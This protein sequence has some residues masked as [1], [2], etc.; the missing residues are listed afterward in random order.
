[1]RLRTKI[2][3]AIV[4]ALLLVPSAAVY[5]VATTESGLRFLMKRLAK[6]GPITLTVTDI[7]GTLTE[8]IRFKS[9]RVQHRLADTTIEDGEGRAKLLPL[10]LR[11]QIDVPSF[12]ARHVT[13]VQLIDPVQRPKR[14]PRFL[15]AML[16]VDAES[17]R[18]GSV[19]LT[20]KNGR[21][22]AFSQISGGATVLPQQIRVRNASA[23]W[24][25][26]TLT[27]NGRVHAARPY[28]LDGQMV[29]VWQPEGQPTWQAAATFDGDLDDLPFNAAVSKPFN[30]TLK[31]NA[32]LR[33][34]WNIAG[35]AVVQD[36][37]LATFGGGNALGLI[38]GRL[39]VDVDRD[40]ITARGELTP[41]GLNA[42]AFGVD[43]RGAYLEKRLTIRE[44]RLVHAPSGARATVRGTAD[45]QP[46]G[47]LLALAGEWSQF[48]WP[49]IGAETAFTSPKGT[50]T[51][52]GSKPWQVRAD[53]D[54]LTPLLPDA[55]A[56]PVQARGQ[57]DGEMFRIDE[58]SAQLL[59]GSASFTG[60][61]RWKPAEGWQVQ[62]HATGLDTSQL[63][64][65]MPGKVSF[66]FRAGGAPFGDAGSIDLAI[67]SLSGTLRGQKAS[68]AGNFARAGGSTDW[69]FRDVDF[70]L[71]SAR[72]RLDGQLGE[73]P[74]LTFAL[75][76]A[77]LSL[78]D[79]DARGQ[80][81]ASGR[82]A[83]TLARPLLKLEARGSGFEWRGYAVAKL[84]A[85]LDIDLTSEPGRTQ[86]SLA[87]VDLGL[88]AR[89]I[90]SASLA[91]T[92]SGTR[93]Q[94][95]LI[96]D[97]APLRAQL[98]AEGGL[99]EGMWRGELTTLTLA[100]EGRDLLR[101]ETVAPIAFNFAQQELGQICLKG[102][103]ERL[104]ASGKHV[105]KGAWSAAFSANAL[106]LATF[107]AG[108][109]QE[110]DYDG[111][112]DL[113]GELSGAPGELPIG[114]VEG[115]LM[116]ARLRHRLGSGRE[117]VMSLGTGTVKANATASNFFFDV[118]MDA[119][120]AGRIRG[121][122][123][124]ERLRADWRDYPITG[125]LDA[126]TDALSLLDIYIGEI[127]KASGRM[128]TKVSIGGTLGTPTVQ[129]TLQLRDA[130]IDIYQINLALRELSLDASFDANAL[131]LS[132]KS[133]VGG[134]TANFNGRLAWR[135][136]QP[137]GQLHVDGDNLQVLNVPEARVRAS[138]DLD[139]K[140]EGRSIDATGT[141]TV[142]YA[143][144]EPLDLTTAVLRSS[145]EQFV[146]APAV[147]PSQ[148][149]TVLSDIRLEMG[150]DVRV[151]ALGL[152]ARLAGGLRLR[153]DAVQNTRAQGELT[154]AE[155]EFEAYGR[156]LEI[157]S[158]GL[159]YTNTPIND[160]GIELR[161]QKVLPEVTAGVIVR[162]TL[163]NRRI[164][165]YSEPAR[166]QLQ[167]MQLLI[168]GDSLAA[169][170]ENQAP[171]AARDD[172]LTQGTAILAQRLGGQ[173]GLDDVGI[174]S[175]ETQTGSLETNL[176]LGKRITDRLYVSYGIS[177]VE[178]I[179]TLK[180]RFTINDR[181]TIRTEAGQERAADIVFTLRKKKKKPDALESP[182]PIP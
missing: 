120:E 97:A 101:N 47:P 62:G 103:Q 7:S 17:V 169:T 119:D 112:I 33:A 122:I 23:G 163:R 98:A 37:D 31:G 8:G 104:C 165:F 69:Q 68:G 155:G 86:G 14:T 154:I 25:A 4:G 145:D 53:G 46:G 126:E 180:L 102:T 136:G 182:A 45:I 128:A 156:Q 87:L 73:K 83:G 59:G 57:L 55:P 90:D 141:V 74:D 51:L 15:P 78:I 96:V 35:Q 20:L 157:V 75:Q 99:Q 143:R 34:D 178:A 127:D 42:G 64:P 176:V 130:S 79:P 124:G 65:D 16:R 113:R 177:L 43:F 172:L 135:D 49:L 19:A 110:F 30:A 129:G 148:N 54:V 109:S 146:N 89:T 166:T 94:L 100:Q 105:V 48:R 2:L 160:P 29:G 114:A 121:R 12:S 88:G 153:S 140:I 132:G 1:M 93:Q 18:I 95:A 174:E 71:G 82:F 118:S 108:L 76:A 139:F 21:Q 116:G 67:A 147:D 167:V 52:A 151:E 134:G 70:T 10:L 63:R 106:P 24:E 6:V 40:G 107:T 158:G 181:W 173:V 38:A 77:D 84:D 36:F 39:D 133:R 144:I 171:G 50:Y 9:L 137:F 27:G 138:P 56:M 161:A 92:G 13:I 58:A 28:G 91:L 44:T 159:Y 123:D 85:D 72:L 80:V 168:G 149:W 117:Q 22:L 164:T 61:A 152:S 170:G 41:A 5:W 175:Y 32:V 125:S 150:S 60:E 131:D 142:P 81:N 111:T 11:R 179:N 26:W 162:G 3:L 66:D 115:Q